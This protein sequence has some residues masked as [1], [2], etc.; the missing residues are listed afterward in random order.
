[1]NN[2]LSTAR[3]LSGVFATT[4]YISIGDPYVK[5]GAVDDREKGK[6]MSADYP[7]LGMSG[8]LQPSALFTKEHRPL[9]AGREKYVDR[10]VYLTT[11]P[12]DTRKRGF[13]SS[14]AKRRDE[15]SN[16][17]EVSKMRERIKQDME[18]AER[19]ARHQE[20]NMSPEDREMVER[21]SQT[22]PR[23]WSHGPEFMFDL[24]KEVTGGTTPYE[25]KDARDTW[26]SRQRV[27][28]ET[29]GQQHLG[30]YVTSSFVVGNNLKDYKAWS[31]PQYA[32]QPTIR[33]SFYRSTGVLR[34]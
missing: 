31:K 21:L 10:T 11:Q 33:D 30:D 28:R 20:E 19:F 13:G 34:G 4:S 2:G 32:R 14:D 22:P 12:P 17:I 6:Q 29:D 18:F 23:R 16:D 15:F 5:K 26:Y 7:K 8:S 24:G 3:A 9:F 1:M 27:K 25:T